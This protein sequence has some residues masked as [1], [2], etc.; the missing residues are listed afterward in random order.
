MQVKDGTSGNEGKKRDI[1]NIILSSI[2]VVAWIAGVIIVSF[3]EWPLF[4]MKQMELESRII[5]FTGMTFVL[6]IFYPYIFLEMGNIKD[7]KKRRHTFIF[8]LGIAVIT[9]VIIPLALQGVYNATKE[10]IVV[11]EDTYVV[12]KETINLET[13]PQFKANLEGDVIIVQAESNIK[14]YVEIVKYCTT[15]TT[16]NQNPWGSKTTETI[17]EWTQYEFHIT[18]PEEND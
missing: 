7:K 18:A 12:S 11:T 13:K 10:N 8:T 6:G 15:L 9:M 14:P 3:F 1:L 4:L 17:K 2:I 16:D 5:L